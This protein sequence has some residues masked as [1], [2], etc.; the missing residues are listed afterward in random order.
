M[1][2]TA[3]Q[4]VS[5][6]ADTVCSLLEQNMKDILT[7][8]EDNGSPAEQVARVSCALKGAIICRN[9]NGDDIQVIDSVIG[10]LVT[11]AVSRSKGVRESASRCAEYIRL[12]MHLSDALPSSESTYG[13]SS[14]NRWQDVLQLMLMKTDELDVVDHFTVDN[15]II[16][17][18]AVSVFGVK[19]AS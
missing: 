1:R 14:V 8:D 15:E 19:D 11:V 16:V 6:T 18:L 9:S 4:P 3:R 7:Y 2:H 13:Q 5:Q 12:A 17:P 10:S